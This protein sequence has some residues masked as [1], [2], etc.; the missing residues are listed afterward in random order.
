MMLVA[1]CVGESQPPPPPKVRDLRSPLTDAAL[2]V[3]DEQPSD[4]VSLPPALCL[5]QRPIP[6]L[7]HCLPFPS[8]L[9]VSVP[10]ATSRTE[11]GVAR[12][13]G[14]LKDHTALRPYHK[15]DGH[16]VSGSGAEESATYHVRLRN[17]PSLCPSP[18]P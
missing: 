9:S 2:H 15:A 6:V 14:A 18:L 5:P 12:E 7:P 16:F 1:Y 8:A 4:P 13:L 11:G 3:T 10:R 17:T